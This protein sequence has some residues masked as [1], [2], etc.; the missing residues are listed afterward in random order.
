MNKRKVITIV[1]FVCIMIAIFLC[2]ILFQS[3]T[4]NSGRIYHNENLLIKEFD[5]YHC[6]N[7]K[8][9]KIQE[10]N[11][12]E[13]SIGR[14]SGVR[15]VKKFEVTENQNHSL[16]YSWD[17]TVDN[18]NFKIVLVDITNSNVEVLCEDSGNGSFS[19][20]S[21]PSGDY[22]IKFV[23]DNATANGKFILF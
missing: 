14:F 20:L 2:I 22:C 16:S 6:N 4:F 7:W 19:N 8:T 11:M 12:I 1:S 3:T 21:L 17:M 15:T 9:N 5:T 10:E 23:G 13:F 18:G